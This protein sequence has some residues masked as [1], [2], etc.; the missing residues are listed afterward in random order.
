MSDPARDIAAL[1]PF[2]A[3]GHGLFT[4][5]AIRIL[6]SSGFRTRSLTVAALL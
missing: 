6:E 3:L 1:L 4:P 2:L 5:P